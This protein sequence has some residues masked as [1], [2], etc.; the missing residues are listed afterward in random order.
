MM[1]NFETELM[2]SWLKDHGLRILVILLASFV[3]YRLLGIF[4][5]FVSRQIQSVDD[6]EDSVL[7]K[8]TATIF[9]AIKST[10]LV[11]IVVTALLMILTELGVEITP[12]LASVG[13][14]GL[15]LGL[16]AQTL[17]QDMIS[18]L[19]ILLENQYG[20]GETVT[21]NGLT[22]TVERMTLRAT[23]IRD[24]YGAIHI[25]PNGGIRIVCNK[26]RD[27]SR[28]IVDVGITYDEDVDLSLQALRDI[29]ELS[30]NE[31]LIA[32]MLL[33]L[34]TVTGI[35]GLDDWAVRLRLMV[36]TLPGQQWEVQR[37]WRRQIRIQFEE[38]GLDLAFP[39]Q[40]VMVLQ[41][42]S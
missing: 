38:K 8:R 21:I 26:S 11:V 12:V 1:S 7:D 32:A 23:I 39:R 19:F 24:L 13:V 42:G 31:E 18:G 30:A 35:E 16:G 25:I 9:R 28:A 36:K 37:Y 17:V 40:D 22:G 6:V 15:A 14:V 27:W 33:E 34:P 29:G 20:L 41:P 5:R 3:S 10:G 2:V 4:T